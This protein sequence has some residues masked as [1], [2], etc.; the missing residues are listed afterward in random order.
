MVK[1]ML[2]I[3]KYGVKTFS[4]RISK[5]KFVARFPSMLHMLRFVNSFDFFSFSYATTHCPAQ[6]LKICPC[7]HD[8]TSNIRPCVLFIR[9]LSDIVRDN[10]LF[11]LQS[12]EGRPN[13][14][15]VF[16]IKFLCRT[17]NWEHLQKFLCGCDSYVHVLLKF[18]FGNS[19]PRSFGGL[20]L[21]HPE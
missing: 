20:D 16:L 7:R 4:A 19:T 2:H 10:L 8:E 15:K 9:F 3:V 14:I 12:S 17:S 13:F 18:H 6:I 11:C 21:T 5:W 1:A